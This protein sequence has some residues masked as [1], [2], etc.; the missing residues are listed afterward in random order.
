MLSRPPGEWRI[1]NSD[2][3]TA[4][5]QRSK[6]RLAVEQ[7]SRCR[8]PSTPDESQVMYKAV[9]EANSPIGEIESD[10]NPDVGP[11][12][13]GNMDKHH[14]DEPNHADEMLNNKEFVSQLP[15][16]RK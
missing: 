2:F 5:R 13:L 4:R 3:G 9:A 8:G 15:N 6:C 7:R 10:R 12:L 11:M 16:R 1:G 14:C